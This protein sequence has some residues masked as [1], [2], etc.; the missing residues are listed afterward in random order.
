[1]ELISTHFCKAANVGYHGNLFGGT[2]LAW[3]DEAGVSFACQI[4][5]TPRM[6]TKKISEVVFHKPVKPGQIIKIYGGVKSIGNR[7][8]VIHLE[9][10]R[11]SVY[12]GNQKTVLTTDMTFVR[13]DGDGEAI[14][15]SQ[16]VKVK[17]SPPPTGSAT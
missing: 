8:I 16:R 10:R 11:H 15:I 9:A 1:V 13:I 3:L 7:S 5:D 6:V 2:M 12:N 4:C 17:H 14:P